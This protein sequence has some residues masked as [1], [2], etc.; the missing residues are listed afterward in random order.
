MAHVIIRSIT[1]IAAGLLATLSAHAQPSLGE[2]CRTLVAIQNFTAASPL[3]E[4]ASQEG[5]VE[6]H[7][8]LGW[9][10]SRG[11]GA[12]KDL[13]AAIAH[14]QFA[15]RAGH[16]QAQMELA[17]AL[18]STEAARPDYA[19]ARYWFGR[20]HDNPT[21]SEEL[22]IDASRRKKLIELVMSPAEMAVSDHLD[23]NGD[24]SQPAKQTVAKQDAANSPKRPRSPV[25]EAQA[26]AHAEAH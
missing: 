3:C 6:A 20:V 15:A 25:P 26:H 9:M 17:N 4:R 1:A 8:W 24:P 14:F 23:A 18:A 2:H 19:R 13:S 7:Y 16:P 5:S 22:R 10:V 12:A 21:A 11:Q